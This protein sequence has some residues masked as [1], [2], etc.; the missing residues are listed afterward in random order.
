MPASHGFPGYYGG[1][2]LKRLREETRSRHEALEAA[3]PLGSAALTPAIYRAVL[4]RFWGFYATWEAEAFAHASNALLPVLVG[5]AKLPMLEADRTALGLNAQACPRMDPAGL[6]DFTAGD[7][8]LLGSMYVVEGAT[9]GGQVISR[10][11]ERNAGFRD[12]LGYSFFQSYGKSVGQQWKTFTALLEAAPE[13]IGDT[14]VASAQQ[15]FHAF[16]C[17]FAEAG[18][19]APK[20]PAVAPGEPR[21]L[22]R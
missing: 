5:R 13:V 20:P 8:T 10:R 4:A 11:L 9:L 15:T 16:S 22:A 14:I 3:L 21:T 17:W 18:F 19:T 1:V 12:G 7:A 6:P 2:I